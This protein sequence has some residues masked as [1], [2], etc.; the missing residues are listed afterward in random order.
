MSINFIAEVS[1]NHS[2][3]LERSIEFVNTAAKIGC[4]SVKFQLFKIDELF[5]P[6]ILLQRKE[7]ADRK[8]WELPIEF[9]EPLSNACKRKD[10]KFSCTPFYLK[11]V[12]E[13]LPYIDFYKIASYELL[14]D[15]L[16]I[17]CAKTGKP[18]IISTGMANTSEINH[19]VKI[20]K[21]N[22]CND[23]TL[24][25]CTSSYPSPYQEVNLSAINTLRELT[26]CN[27][28]WSDH[29]YDPGVIYRSINKWN[30]TAIEFHLDLEGQGEEYS[31]GHCWLPHEIQSIIEGVNHGFSAD[32][33]GIKEPAKCELVERE[34]R[35]DPSDGLRPLLNTR[36]QFNKT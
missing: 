28:G 26:G 1:S 9:L 24:M 32:G 23:L 3:S 12:D 6:E 11:A 7:I 18:L 31:S 36:K 25:H 27:V 2:Q 35:A 15:E 5:A 20:I 22:G 16:L 34:W 29:S 33:H 30:A 21:N 4:E 13:L 19:A 17:K 10:I 14:W 8:N